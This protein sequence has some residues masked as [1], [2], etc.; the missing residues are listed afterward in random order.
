AALK[1]EIAKLVTSLRGVPGVTDATYMIEAVLPSF[2]LPGYGLRGVPLYLVDDAERYRASVYAEPS[3][4][5]SDA[6][7]AIAS[8]MRDEVAVSPPIADFWRVEPGSQ[9]L[10]GMDSDRR[11]SSCSFR[12]APPPIPRRFN[13]RS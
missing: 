5:L 4:G 8:K 11:A 13:R 10:L 2:Y 12:R 1:P 9:M 7:D 3:V 6:F